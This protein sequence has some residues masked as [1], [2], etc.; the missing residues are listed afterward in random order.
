MKYT[1]YIEAEQNRVFFNDKDSVEM[2]CASIKADGFS[3]I[4]EAGT[5]MWAERSSFDGRVY[6]YD[7]SRALEMFVEAEALYEEQNPVIPEDTTPT[8][9]ALQGLLA[10]DQSGLSAEYTQWATDPAR[11]FAEKAYID[12]ATM[13]RRDE[14]VLNSAAQSMGLTSEQVDE[15]FV[16]AATL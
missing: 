3:F 9:T 4:I 5:E 11:T 2:D 14:P 15:L 16:L 10:L 13:W 8:V 1:R 6:D 12:K 7:F